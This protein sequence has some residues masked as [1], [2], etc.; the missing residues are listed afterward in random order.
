MKK[1]VKVKPLVKRVVRDFLLDYI[2][3]IISHKEFDVA[4]V[5]GGTAYQYYDRIHIINNTSLKTF[6]LDFF[7][8]TNLNL[9]CKYGLE[10]LKSLWNKLLTRFWR[11]QKSKITEMKKKLNSILGLRIQVPMQGIQKSSDFIFKS[12]KSNWKVMD[13]ID[14]MKTYFIHHVFINVGNK[15]LDILQCNVKPSQWLYQQQSMTCLYSSAGIYICSINFLKRLLQYAIEN[16]P[17]KFKKKEK[18]YSRILNNCE[19]FN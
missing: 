13:G 3:F 16:C 6:D 10:R 8:G 18:K 5:Y 9:D 19:Y 1:K 7:V 14:F 12:N 17:K 4:I 15:K 2:E 11:S